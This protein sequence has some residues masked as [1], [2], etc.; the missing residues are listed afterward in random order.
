MKFI[1]MNSTFPVDLHNVGAEEIPGKNP[2]R[3]ISGTSTGGISKTNSIGRSRHF[4]HLAA[5]EVQPDVCQ[6]APPPQTVGAPSL[7][8]SW[9][10]AASPEA[11]LRLRLNM[12]RGLSTHPAGALDPH[13]CPMKL[14]ST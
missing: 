6:V 9:Q 7:A 13:F 2:H 3:T 10:E 1:S 8:V 14:T 5:L 12:K 11:K 4:F